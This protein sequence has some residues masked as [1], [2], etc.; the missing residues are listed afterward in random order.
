MTLPLYPGR[1]DGQ[2]SDL[3]PWLWTSSVSRTLDYKLTLVVHGCDV[4]I[5]LLLETPILA[6]QHSTV[7]IAILSGVEHF[8]TC[9]RG[10]L[11]ILSP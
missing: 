11:N 9:S 6:K 5:Q 3:V 7:C 1:A 2:I 10:L 8:L 4:L